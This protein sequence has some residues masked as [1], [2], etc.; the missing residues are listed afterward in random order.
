MNARSIIHELTAIALCFSQHRC[1]IPYT[2]NLL[3]YALFLSLC[4]IHVSKTPLFLMRFERNS[5][6]IWLALRL[7]FVKIV[8]TVLRYGVWKFVAERS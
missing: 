8:G 3:P 6:S 4:S 7:N 2:R 5:K 1:N